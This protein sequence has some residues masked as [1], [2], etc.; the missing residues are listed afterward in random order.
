M[1]KLLQH[2]KYL[3]CGI[4]SIL[5]KHTSYHLS[6]FFFF[7]FNFHD[8]TFK[9][10]NIKNRIV[11]HSKTNDHLYVRFFSYFPKPLPVAFSKYYLLLARSF[12]LASWS[13]DINWTHVICLDALVIQNAFWRLMYVQ[14]RFC[15]KGETCYQV[16]R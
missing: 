2:Y 10:P 12:E 13:Q 3:E 7:F 1:V 8:C 11:P 5:S 14:L 6:V 9:P 4:F 16:S 15:A